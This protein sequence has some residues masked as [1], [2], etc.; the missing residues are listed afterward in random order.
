[1]MG[2]GDSIY[3]QDWKPFTREEIRRH[4]G[5]Y[6]FNGVSPTP[7]I[8]LRFHSQSKDPVHGNDMIRE[9][10]GLNARTRHR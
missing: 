5:L 10:F 9:A 2:A 4:L 1:M 7:Q 8:T 3:K 6:I